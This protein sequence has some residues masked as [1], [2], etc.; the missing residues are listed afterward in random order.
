MKFKRSSWLLLLLVLFLGAASL[1]SCGITKNNKD[2][3]CPNKI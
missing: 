1:Q 2:C 3:G